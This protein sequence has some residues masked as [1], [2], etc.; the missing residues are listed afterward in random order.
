MSGNSQQMNST[1]EEQLSSFQNKLEAG[2]CEVR[3]PCSPK[4]LLL[5]NCIAKKDLFVRVLS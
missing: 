1:I 3:L 4:S 2:A 5:L